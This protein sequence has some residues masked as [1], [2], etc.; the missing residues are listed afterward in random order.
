MKGNA[1]HDRT[2]KGWTPK[3]KSTVK[4]D[5]APHSQPP[6]LEAMVNF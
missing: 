1:G 3:I 2:I 5:F 4:L 6:T